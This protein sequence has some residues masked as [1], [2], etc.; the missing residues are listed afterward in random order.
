MQLVDRGDLLLLWFT[1]GDQGDPAASGSRG[2]NGG[3][4]L[5]AANLERRNHLR[6]DDDLAQWDE[7]EGATA[8]WHDS[9]VVACGD[10]LVNGELLLF[11][12][13][14]IKVCLNLSLGSLAH[15][16]PLPAASC[17]ARFASSAWPSSYSRSKIRS[18][19]RSSSSKRSLMPAR[20]TPKSCVRWRIQ[21][22]R[23]RSFSEKRRMFDS[24][25][26]GQIR[27]SSS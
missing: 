1:L 12:E 27:P 20:L 2:A 26:E 15:A 17:G 10:S 18:P 8:T 22:M 9:F 13:L 21:R 19:S 16:R 7:G 14:L 3:N 23:R 11:V 6:E 4:A 25:R 5:I 24:V